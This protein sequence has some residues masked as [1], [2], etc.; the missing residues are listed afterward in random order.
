MDD[1]RGRGAHDVEV[2]GEGALVEVVQERDEDQQRPGNDQ[3]PSTDI[4]RD[5]QGRQPQRT[6]GNCCLGQPLS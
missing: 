1:L 5:A 6:D 2:G 4:T 3:T